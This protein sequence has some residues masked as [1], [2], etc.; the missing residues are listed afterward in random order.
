[1]SSSAIARDK[2]DGVDRPSN[3]SF[4]S[5]DSW[6]SGDAVGKSCEPYDCLGAAAGMNRCQRPAMACVHGIE[7]S[8][9]FGTTNFS[10][11]D[12][13]GPVTQNCLQQVVEADLAAMSVGL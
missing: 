13:V 3:L 8:S 11:D 4:G 12:A 7:K 6:R 10:D 2:Y 9:G 1:M 5:L